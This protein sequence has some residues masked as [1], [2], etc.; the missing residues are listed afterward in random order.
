MSNLP[1]SPDLSGS[2]AIRPEASSSANAANPANSTAV[3]AHSAHLTFAQSQWDEDY[4]HGNYDFDPAYNDFALISLTTEE[5]NDPL[6]PAPIVFC[7]D[8]VLFHTRQEYLNSDD[9][10]H[11]PVPDDIC[12]DTCDLYQCHNPADIYDGNSHSD[13]SIPGLITDSDTDSDSDDYPYDLNNCVYSNNEQP[14]ADHALVSVSTTG[15]CDTV[16][17]GP[18]VFLT[19]DIPVNQ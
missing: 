19:A 8:I 6:P 14:A 3:N 17:P 18:I 4:Y 10:H 7:D 1:I 12:D 11:R 2:H 13:D 16:L 15:E 9:T 5:G